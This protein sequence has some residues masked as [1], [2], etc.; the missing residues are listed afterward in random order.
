MKYRTTFLDFWGLGSLKKRD[1]DRQTLRLYISS[2][3]LSISISIATF[4]YL[5]IIRNTVNSVYYHF[6]MEMLISLAF[7]DATLRAYSTIPVPATASVNI[8][9]NCCFSSRASIRWFTPLGWLSSP[10]CLIE[11]P[12]I[13]AAARRWASTDKPQLTRH[14]A[15]IDFDIAL[16]TI[17]QHLRLILTLHIY[18]RK[19]ICC[20]IEILLFQLMSRITIDLA[21]IMLER[22]K[23]NSRR[24]NV[25]YCCCRWM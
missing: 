15:F 6:Q 25:E 23:N 5:F 7:Q 4:L 22:L 21:A 20:L 1:F 8:Q 9:L 2:I 13:F 18:G 11:M 16:L 10:P 19:V 3:C 12:N 24:K 17:E 14:A